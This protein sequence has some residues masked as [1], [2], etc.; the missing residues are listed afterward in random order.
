MK[1]T[2]CFLLALVM[3]AGLLCGCGHPN[4]N[5]VVGVWEGTGD[6]SKVGV[7]VPADTVKKLTFYKDELLT[8]ETVRADGSIRVDEYRWYVTDSAMT[9]GRVDGN[10]GFGVPY[11]LQGSKLLI[12]DGDGGYNTFHRV[13]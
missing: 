2:G 1:K 3:I 5:K 9:F 11:K 13:E 12:G 8:V 6:M 10:G 4:R 7:M